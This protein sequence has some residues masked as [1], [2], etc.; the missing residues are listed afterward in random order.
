MGHPGFNQA[1]QLM[2]HHQQ[3]QQNSLYSQHQQQMPAQRADSV[4]SMPAYLSS[5]RMRDSMPQMIR[6]DHPMNIKVAFNNLGISIS[7]LSFFNPFL[8]LKLGISRNIPKHTEQQVTD[9][10]QIACEVRRD[11][12]CDYFFCPWQG[13]TF[14]SILTITR[15][16]ECPK[17]FN[18][19]DSL[20]RHLR[21]HVDVRSFQCEKCD[22]RFLRSD[23]LRC[24]FFH[25][26]FFEWF[27]S[28]Y[29][30][31]YWRATFRLHRLRKY[32][33]A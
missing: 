28:S 23:H 6:H 14:L 24:H 15:S 9:L 11:Q 3:Q 30:E 8:A 12:E 21:V 19:R 26:S 18:R 5:F 1:M 10:L 17:F 4:Q 13:R 29:A 31:A 25:V 16:L 27:Q 32:F 2:Q 33:C 22:Q 20:V 7:C